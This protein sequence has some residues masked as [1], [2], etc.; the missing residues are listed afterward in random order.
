MPW[1]SR[2]VT[3]VVFVGAVILIALWI[4][5]KMPETEVGDTFTTCARM[6]DGSRLATGS[7]VLI[8]GVRV[9]EVTNLSVEG[10]F[11]RIDMVLQDGIDIPIDSWVTKRAYSPFGDSYVEIIPTGGELGAPTAQRLRS[12]QCL[13]RVLEGSSTDRILR[14]MDDVMPRVVRGLDRIHEVAMYGRKWAI[15]TLEDRM[16]DAE[17]WLDE[18]HVSNPLRKADQ[19]LARLEAGATAMADRVHGAQPRVDDGLDRV[20]RGIANA[21]KQMAELTVNLKDGMKNVRA[22]MDGLDKPAADYAELMAAVDEGRGDNYQ[23]TLGRMI[24]DPKL[25]DTI[26]DGTESMR[27][28]TSSFSRFK[29][30]LGLRSEW[31]IFSGAPHVYVTAEIRARTDKFYYLELERGPLGDFPD[32]QIS[33]MVGVPQYTRYQEIRD[34]IR[35]TVQFGKTFGNWFQVRGGIKESTFGFGADMLLR[36]GK[37]RFSGDVFGSFQRTPRVKLGA[38]LEVF[39]SLYVIAGV[40]DAI[41]TPGYL[42]IVKGN[43]DVPTRFDEVRF[44]RDYFLGAELKFDD[45]DLSMLL[46]IYGALLVGLL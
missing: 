8:A 16:I 7:P 38:A 42:S 31:L 40:D 29:S 1:L 25:A 35:F 5:S 18:G 11:A 39:R 21:R 19:A 20:D 43:E 28:G 33:D 10:T 23:G 24:N 6:R 32:G 4:R 3:I 9:G 37:L 14:A 17:R 12:G 41:N 13:T 46:R 26:Q 30:Y 44:G 15:G 2:L 45:A 27:E 34:R 36:Q 22:G